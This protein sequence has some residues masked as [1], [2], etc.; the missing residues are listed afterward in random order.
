M[1]FVKSYLSFFIDLF[2]EEHEKQNLL[3]D[4]LLHYTNSDSTPSWDEFGHALVDLGVASY[5]SLRTF[6]TCLPDHLPNNQDNW[7]WTKAQVA[8]SREWAWIPTF[9][10]EFL[11]QWNRI[12]QEWNLQTVELPLSDGQAVMFVAKANQV[13]HFLKNELLSSL[14]PVHIHE[15]MN[16]YTSLP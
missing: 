11:R 7:N 6:P 16:R 14:P 15:P 1:S 12:L 8:E 3:Q 13:Q 9:A 5:Y 2:P 10:N 4:R